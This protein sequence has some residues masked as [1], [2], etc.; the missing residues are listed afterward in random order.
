MSANVSINHPKQRLLFFVAQDV[1][2]DVRAEVT[3][4][5]ASLANARRWTIHP[6]RLI[7]TIDDIG[8]RPQDLPDETLG[9]MLEIYSALSPGLPRDVDVSHL[10]EVQL[11]I[12]A[13]QAVSREKGLAFEFELDGVFVG[14]IEDGE[15]DRT[16]SE[17]LLSEWN[18]G[19]GN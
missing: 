12:R 5:I 8:S 10:E 4:L 3:K 16:L 7:D 1:D 13:V 15:M 17:G 19:G 6:P 2:E 9:G 11:I 18:R 14:A